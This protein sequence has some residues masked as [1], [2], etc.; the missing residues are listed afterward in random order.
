MPPV[1]NYFRFVFEFLNC[2]ARALG[3]ALGDKVRLFPWTT[4]LRVIPE[5]DVLSIGDNTV[6]CAHVYGHDFSNMHL[7]FKRTS[8]GSD[9]KLV[10][11]V[12]CQILPGSELPDGTVVNCVGRGVSFQGLVTEPGRTWSGNPF[13]PQETMKMAPKY[14][15]CV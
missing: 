15:E 2:Y 7:R 12:A 9:C 4:F 8:L 1:P 14:A 11:S 5:A 13:Q 3:V 10:D 6:N